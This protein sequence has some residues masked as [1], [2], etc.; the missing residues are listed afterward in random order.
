MS[1][2]RQTLFVITVSYSL[3]LVLHIIIAHMYARSDDDD[4][5]KITTCVT[6]KG[7]IFYFSLET[8]K[9]IFKC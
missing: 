5:K 7:A 4:G 6:D 9:I 1:D 2:N 3:N 8:A